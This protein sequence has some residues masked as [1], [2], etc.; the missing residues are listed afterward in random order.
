VSNTNCHKLEKMVWVNKLRLASVG[1]FCTSEKPTVKIRALIYIYISALVKI[2]YWTE[3]SVVCF[4]TMDRSLLS[5]TIISL[6]HLATCLA[7]LRKTISALQCKGC[8][9][10]A[11][12]PQSLLKVESHY[13][14]RNGC[15][16]NNT[17]R[18]DTPCAAISRATWETSLRDK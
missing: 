6:L 15:C 12:L 10:V 8:Y 13:T 14:S 11:T 2:V 17:A 1:V 9:T 16:N 4:K 5:S 18:H 7:M 3:N